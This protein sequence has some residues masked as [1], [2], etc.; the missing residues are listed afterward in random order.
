MFSGKD[1]NDFRF[2]QRRQVGF[3]FPRHGL[4]PFAPLGPGVTS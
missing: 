4:Y 2:T 3:I 1:L